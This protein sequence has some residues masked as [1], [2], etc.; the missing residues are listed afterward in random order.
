MKKVSEL[1]LDVLIEDALL[2][3]LV[4]LVCECD[5]M[6]PIDVS[7]VAIA[8]AGGGIVDLETGE[9]FYQRDDWPAFARE[10]CRRRVALG[11]P[12]EVDALASAIE[13]ASGFDGDVCL[14]MARVGVTLWLSGV[15]SVGC[16]VAG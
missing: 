9:V 4:D 11:K 6:Q 16:G 13:K 2:D 3:D 5:I 10:W 15:W 7:T 1:S 12:V 8:E 14:G